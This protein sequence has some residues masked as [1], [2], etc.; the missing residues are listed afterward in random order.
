[1]SYAKMGGPILT[2]YTSHMACSCAKYCLLES[3]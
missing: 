3:H 2:F 1:V